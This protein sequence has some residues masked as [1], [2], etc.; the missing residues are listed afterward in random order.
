MPV[1]TEGRDADITAYPNKYFAFVYTHQ[2]R[3]HK[4]R[5]LPHKKI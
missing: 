2:Q 1:I 5:D 4:I 3:L